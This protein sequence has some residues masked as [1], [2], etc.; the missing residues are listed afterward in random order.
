ME[1][2]TQP[3][4]DNFAVRR[5]SDNR[6]APEPFSRTTLRKD[7]VGILFKR[8][9]P[10]D[11]SQI[12]AVVDTAIRRIERNLPE[13]RTHLTEEEYRKHK[14]IVGAL[15]DTVI[16]DAVE[17]EL[18]ERGGGSFRM[19]EL[20]YA[21]AIHGRNDNRPGWPDAAAVMA[22]VHERYSDI[23]AENQRGHF[24]HQPWPRLAAPRRLDWRPETV[25][26]RDGR[27]PAFAIKQL[28]KG[29]HAALWGRADADA[30]ALMIAHLVLSDL[31]GQRIVQST[32][33]SHSVL[34]NLRRV[35]DIGYLRWAT[36]VKNIRGIREFANEAT[37]LINAPSP[38]LHVTK[39]WRHWARA[40]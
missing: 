34:L 24:T 33:I 25:L 20:L 36:I 3:D 28:R 26:K 35:D 37:D 23:H 17:A 21:M 8:K 22:W 2:P 15:P 31:R 6:L 5:S 13:A 29:I 4:L 38:R 10:L 7:I 40:K 19:A 14:L 9:G 39:D 1:V 27:R 18:A 12:D 11:D 32:Q 30:K 16:S